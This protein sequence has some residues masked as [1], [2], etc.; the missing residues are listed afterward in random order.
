MLE[1]SR[2]DIGVAKFPYSAYLKWGGGGGGFPGTNY[3]PFIGENAANIYRRYADPSSNHG[4]GGTSSV[5]HR[6]PGCNDVVID[7]AGR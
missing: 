2:F 4:Q 5:G 3:D 6:T 1:S 7:A